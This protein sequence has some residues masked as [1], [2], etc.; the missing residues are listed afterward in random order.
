VKLGA[1]FQATEEYESRGGLNDQ[2]E[3]NDHRWH[4]WNYDHEYG[5]S[6]HRHGR[7]P[8]NE[9]CTAPGLHVSPIAGWILHFV[10]GISFA[11]IYTF[12]VMARLS[13]ISSRLGRGIIF[14]LIA[15][16]VAM[17]SIPAM[18]VMFGRMPQMV[19]S[20]PPMAAVSIIEH[21]AFGI[22]VVLIFD[23]L[24]T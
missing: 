15:F 3:R 12:L 17:I 8:Q 20:A 22:A 7:R 23:K 6:A 9:L 24:S 19:A 11:L 18:G 5:V 13:R 14:G 4:W 2:V 21:V 10:V 1:S 16:L